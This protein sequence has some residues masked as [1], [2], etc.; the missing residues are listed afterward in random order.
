MRIAAVEDLQ[1]DG[2][3]RTYAFQTIGIGQGLVDWA[4]LHDGFGVGG[5]SALICKFAPVAIV[6]PVWSGV[7]QA[8]PAS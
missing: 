4:E 8:T 1:A 5:V 3:W 6:D 2:G 7:W